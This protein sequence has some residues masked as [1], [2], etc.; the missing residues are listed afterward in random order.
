MKFTIEGKGT[1]AVDV[2]IWDGIRPSGTR[3]ELKPEYVKSL[4]AFL[5][6][7]AKSRSTF[8]VECDEPSKTNGA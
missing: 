3:V 7:A 8:T 2:I 1:G 4:L 6:K 5:S